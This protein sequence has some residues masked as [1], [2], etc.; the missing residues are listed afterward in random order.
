MEAGGAKASRMD[1][2]AREEGFVGHL[3]QGKA[4]GKR[5]GWEYGGAMDGAGQGLREAGIGH[6]V[7]GGDI[8]GTG[9]I[10][11]VQCEK[12]GGDGVSERD[13]THPLTARA[14]PSAKAEAEEG[15]HFCECAGTGMENDA[16]AEMNDANAGEA[17][18]V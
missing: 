11:G 4:Q 3:T 5:R 12:G 17:C 15:Q 14:E 16:E 6:R 1:A 18:G 8:D 13:P 9:E 7:G 10:L 2:G